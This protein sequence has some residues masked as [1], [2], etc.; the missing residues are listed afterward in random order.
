MEEPGGGGALSVHGQRQRPLPHGRVPLH[1][2][3]G[4]GQLYTP[5]P[6]QL[7]R[8]EGVRVCT[9]CVGCEGVCV[10]VAYRAWVCTVCTV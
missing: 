9:V 5:Q 8:C 3:R 10:C 7:N 1:T 2:A 4:G 6:H